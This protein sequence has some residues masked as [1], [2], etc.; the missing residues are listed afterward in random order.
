MA[1]G[2]IQRPEARPAIPPQQDEARHLCD[3][4]AVQLSGVVAACNAH[5]FRAAEGW[6]FDGRVLT[7]LVPSQ[8]HVE[9]LSSDLYRERLSRASAEI[10][11][12]GLRFAFLVSAPATPALHD[13]AL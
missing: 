2:E 7:L 5:W 13:G 9:W 8:A 6:L 3:A 4:I 1:R 11:R 10:D 12:R